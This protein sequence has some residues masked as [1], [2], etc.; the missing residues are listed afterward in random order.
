M[1][2]FTQLSEALGEVVKDRMHA[3]D[4]GAIRRRLLKINETVH[5][6]LMTAFRHLEETLNL[7]GYTFISQVDDEFD[8]QAGE[9]DFFV[10]EANSGDVVKNV[11]LSVQWSFI[12]NVHPHTGKEFNASVTF[13]LEDIDAEDVESVFAEDVSDIGEVVK[14]EPEEEIA[15]AVKEDTPEDRPVYEANY[16]RF[17]NLMR[18]LFESGE[19]DD[20]EDE[21]DES[22]ILQK[23]KDNISAAVA[24]IA[25]DGSMRDSVKF[26]EG[27]PFKK[28]VEMTNAMLDDDMAKVK[29]MVKSLKK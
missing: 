6:D 7:H 2:S 15:E 25:F 22:K 13:R 12:N 10:Y 17:D 14:D 26:L 18:V 23:H 11:Y 4:A 1:K 21:L 24:E 19:E 28:Y 3:G 8:E 29:S 27:I 5:Q 16:D 9:D 20:E